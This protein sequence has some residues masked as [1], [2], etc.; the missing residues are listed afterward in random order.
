MGD[1]VCGQPAEVDP[2]EL[3]AALGAQSQ[4][5]E[6]LDLMKHEQDALNLLKEFQRSDLGA[7]D[8]RDYAAQDIVS[9]PSILN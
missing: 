6:G 9:Q 3:K 4:A 2:D 8:L 5:I 1:I 7:S